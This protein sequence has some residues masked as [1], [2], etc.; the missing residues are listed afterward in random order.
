M[1]MCLN[2]SRTKNF[3]NT[4]FANKAQIVSKDW[5]T[6][7]QRRQRVSGEFLPLC[8]SANVMRPRRD[9]LGSIFDIGSINVAHIGMHHTKTW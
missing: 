8:L 7:M 1:G 6:K 9:M 2:I 3:K 5:E 4:R